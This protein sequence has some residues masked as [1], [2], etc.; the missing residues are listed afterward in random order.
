M[1]QN[2]KSIWSVIILIATIVAL[3]LLVT[4]I[5]V[6]ALGVPTALAVAKQ[7]AIDGGVPAEEAELAAGLAIGAIIAA[8]V[9]SSVFDVL[10]IIGGFMFSLKG[11]WGLFCI[12]VSIISAVIGIWALISNIVNKAG[13]GSIVVS[14]LELAVSGVL[15]VACFKHRAENNAA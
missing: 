6:T 12:I 7:A 2:K 8:L 11:R 9:F 15:V 14:A 5:V 4:S 1:A 10:K 13:V 3:A